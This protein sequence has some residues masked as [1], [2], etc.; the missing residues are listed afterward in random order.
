MQTR[1]PVA[2]IRLTRTANRHANLACKLSDQDERLLE[3]CSEA[4]GVATVRRVSRRPS[5]AAS[6]VMGPVTRPCRTRDAERVDDRSGRGL[7]L[8]LLRHSPA[9]GCNNASGT[10]VR[11]SD[12]GRYYRSAG[13][14]RERASA[15]YAP[16]GRKARVLRTDP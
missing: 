3:R 13:G 10:R 12:S 4:G 16:Y 7:A 15:S 1:G 8:A 2:A 5:S 11:L 14:A 6:R 9:S